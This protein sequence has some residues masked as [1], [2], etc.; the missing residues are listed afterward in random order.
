[1]RTLALAALLAAAALPAQA[2]EGGRDPFGIRT[3]GVTTVVP[4]NG[5]S[6]NGAPVTQLAPAPVRKPVRR[7][8]RP[9]APR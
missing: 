9:A 4:Q 6:Q 3:P 1:M 2:Q 7:A 5:V 8:P